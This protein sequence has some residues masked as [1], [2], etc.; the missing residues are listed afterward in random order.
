MQLFGK[1]KA[2]LFADV[3]PGLPLLWQHLIN[4]KV[5]GLI[6]FWFHVE[7]LGLGALGRDYSL[8]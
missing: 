3:G 7:S 1:P 5:A 6:L 4:R 2:A 8:L